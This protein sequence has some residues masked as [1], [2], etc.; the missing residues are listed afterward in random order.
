[1][2]RRRT[3]ERR[4]DQIGHGG[5]GV[6]TAPSLPPCIARDRTASGAVVVVVRRLKVG[7]EWRRPIAV[8]VKL[9]HRK[10]A[11]PPFYV[12]FERR[13]QSDRRVLCGVSLMLI[14]RR[15]RRLCHEGGE[16]P[17]F[18]PFL[19]FRLNDPLRSPPPPPPI[20]L[21][22]RLRS[23]SFILTLSRLWISTLTSPQLNPLHNIHSTKMYHRTP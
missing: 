16:L 8:V 10:P 4:G 19:W 23:F 1:M 18:L 6:G 5:S 2:R 20:L 7:A 3:N 14:R 9:S 15:R 11:G 12:L 17:S 13:S 21:P 22:L